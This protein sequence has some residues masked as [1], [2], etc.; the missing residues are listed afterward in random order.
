VRV[1]GINLQAVSIATA[2]TLLA[3]LPLGGCG[4]TGLDESASFGGG[5]SG[6]AG[7]AGGGTSGNGGQG[8]PS[9]PVSGGGSGGGHAGDTGG[10][11]SGN[12]GH[13]GSST[14][15][16]AA[17]AGT[18]PAVCG[19]GMVECINASQ[20]RVC[21][22]GAWGTPVWCPRGCSQGVCAEC[23]PGTASCVSSSTLQVCNASGTFD[24]VECD[25]MCAGNAC[26]ACVEGS[27]RCSV[28]NVRGT[29]KGIT[30]PNECPEDLNPHPAQ[31]ICQG[32]DWTVVNYACEFVCDGTAC[33]QKP[34]MVFV[35]SD[36][37]VGGSLGGL[38]GADARCTKLAAGANLPPG[39]Y[40]A[41]LS[42]STGSPA[43]RFPKDVGPYVLVDG[44]IVANN[45][46]ELTADGRLFHP[47]DLTQ[48]GGTPPTVTNACGLDL[49]TSV[50][51]NTGYDG[52]IF[53]PDFSCGNWSDPMARNAAWGLMDGG[54]DWSN[55]CSLSDV[56][57]ALACG[58]AA[59]LYCFQQ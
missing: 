58:S 1:V 22:G 56:A 50:W 38:A 54:N 51:S 19:E 33:G 9:E 59:P 13:A 5:S 41:W 4:R 27:T 29:C 42:D 53:S 21:S 43:S 12:S 25:G 10:E 14:A 26:V 49:D 16:G 20:A 52:N 46:I 31:Q 3:V 57:P 6:A 28:V 18:Q 2:A 55:G 8:G 24:A 48:T 15:V 36:T 39:P 34:K 40:L 35:T 7:H 44:T 30:G 23:V 17:G 37:F 11:T 32:G 47:L 45:W